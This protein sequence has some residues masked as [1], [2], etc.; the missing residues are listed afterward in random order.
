M[1]NPL[2][3]R[4]LNTPIIISS[5]KTKVKNVDNPDVILPSQDSRAHIARWLDAIN[6]GIHINGRAKYLTAFKSD[7]ETRM[8][9]GNEKFLST[10][11]A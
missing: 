1:L 10:C 5:L 7:F 6:D 8:N 4:T 9:F 11:T 3:C 2:A